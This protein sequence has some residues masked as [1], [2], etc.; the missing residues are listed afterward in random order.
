[1]VGCETS[2]LAPW[3]AGQAAV[4]VSPMGRTA[5]TGPAVPPATDVCRLHLRFGGPRLLGWPR[6]RT[7]TRKEELLFRF[8][9]T[10]TRTTQR[11]LEDKTMGT[12]TVGVPVCRPVPSG[13]VG[14]HTYAGVLHNSRRQV[15]QLHSVF[16]YTSDFPRLLSLESPSTTALCCDMLVCLRTTLTPSTPFS[17]HSGAW[18]HLMGVLSHSSIM[19][20]YCPS[21]HNHGDNVRKSHQRHLN[22]WRKKYFAPYQSIKPPAWGS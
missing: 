9:K 13:T 22:G 17:P 7:R 3:H 19:D 1:M 11:Q 20:M 10:R 21:P 14:I 12:T 8:S 4:R 15:S 16:Y 6:V 5:S 18:S 2:S